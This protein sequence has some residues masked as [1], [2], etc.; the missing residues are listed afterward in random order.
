MSSELKTFLTNLGISTSRT[1]PY[2]PQGNSQCERYNGIIWC[3][4]TLAL[5]SK[6]LSNR[7]WEAVLPD[8]LHSIRSLLCTGTNETPHGRLFS[9]PR[10]SATGTSLPAW[11]TSPGEAVLLKRHVRNKTDPLVDQVVLVEANPHFAYVRHPTGKVD[12]VS[13]RDLAPCPAGQQPTEELTPPCESTS[14]SGSS[15]PRHP[16]AA[17]PSAGLGTPR[18]AD[19]VTSDTQS[20][21]TETEAPYVSPRRGPE[22]EAASRAPL[23]QSS[24]PRK[25]VT[26]LDL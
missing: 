23:R 14:P 18:R 7:L 21:G 24:R 2:H 5:E 11:L 4:V 8:A 26:R 25:P 19:D 9:Y 22:I 10:R 12:T 20:M 13:T 3:T 16:P 15:T 1:T 17:E 6:G